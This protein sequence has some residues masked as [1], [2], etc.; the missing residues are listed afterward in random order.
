MTQDCWC[1]SPAGDRAGGARASGKRLGQRAF[2][3]DRLRAEP[4]IGTLTSRAFCHL[5]LSWDWE[6]PTK[7]AFVVREV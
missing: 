7:T 6:Q 4:A 1:L 3:A 2:G 5:P